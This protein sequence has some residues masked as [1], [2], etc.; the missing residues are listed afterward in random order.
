MRKCL[1]KI[2]T[3]GI[4]FF[5]FLYRNSLLDISCVYISNILPFPSFPLFH[6]PSSCLYEDAPPPT[7]PLRPPCPGIP[8]H[9]GKKPS[10]DQGLILPFVSNKAILC[11]ICGW[12]RRSLH[13]YSLVG[14]LVP[15][16]SEGRGVWLTNIIVFLMEL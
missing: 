16:R 12:S 15:R 10:Q 2:W 5:L 6:S 7:H 9:W 1:H 3:Q 4:F 11:Y 14:G 13:V 8:L